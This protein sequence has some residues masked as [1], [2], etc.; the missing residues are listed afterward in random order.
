MLSKAFPMLEL[1]VPRLINLAGELGRLSREVDDSGLRLPGT[2]LLAASQHPLPER[3]EA[4]PAIGLALE[5][6]QAVNMAIHRSLRPDEREDID[7]PGR[8]PS[9]RCDDSWKALGE[10][11]V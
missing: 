3:L 10:D 2:A 11:V 1:D 6:L 9:V 5:E 4:R 7:E 8:A